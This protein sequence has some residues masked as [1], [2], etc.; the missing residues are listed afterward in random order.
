VRLDAQRSL[1]AALAHAREGQRVLP[2]LGK[3]PRTPHGVEDATHD[4]AT[5]RRWWE[6]WPDANLGVAMDGCAAIDVDSRTGGLETLGELEKRYGPFPVTRTVATGGGG[7]HLIYKLNGRPVRSGSGRLGPGIDIKAGGAAYLV[8]PPSVHPDTRERYKVLNDVP[9]ATLPGWVVDAAA[10][11]GSVDSPRRGSRLVELLDDP[12][13]EGARNEWLAQVAG[14]YATR[15]RHSD[16]Y[17]W[18]VTQANELLDQPLDEDEVRRTAESIWRSE[19]AKRG[20]AAGALRIVSSAELADRVEHAPP[21][22][23]LVEPVWPADA[24]GV[25]AAEQK[26]GKTW[27]GLDLIVSVASGTAWMGEF[28]ARRGGVLGF[29]GEGGERKMH[30]RLAAVCRPRGLDLRGLPIRLCFRVP[31]LTDDDHLAAVEAEL[32]A[33]RPS[34]VYLDPLYLAA[35]GARGSQLYEMGEHLQRIQLACQEHGAALLIVHHWN[36]TG[37]GR[38]AKRMTGVGPGEWGRVLVSMSVRSR[39]TDPETRATDTIIDWIFEGDEI[40]ETE[41]RIRRRVRAEDPDSLESPLHYEVERVEAVGGADDDGLSPAQQR[42]RAALGAG[43]AWM[44]VAQIG[45][46]L[47]R[48]GSPLKVRT[49]QEALKRLRA[50]GFATSDASVGGRAFRWR[51]ATAQGELL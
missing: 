38:G 20:G 48:E 42:V 8:A 14:H 31:V 10:G 2:L 22:G 44:T 47:A 49:I 12:P 18:H 17:L 11:P 32:R 3:V 41:L 9:P 15:H 6:R 50:E 34:L 7:L 25:L 46:A 33:H 19:S 16:D 13:G 35:R 45:D 37:E 21:V 51:S 43:G 28:P 24:Y 26:A 39:R 27:A 1:A 29:L 36:K 40:P 5:I 30:R 4:E 23:W